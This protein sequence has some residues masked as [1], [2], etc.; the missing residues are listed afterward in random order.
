[1][2]ENLYDSIKYF[3]DVEKAPLKRPLH[4]HIVHSFNRSKAKYEIFKIGKS[5]LKMEP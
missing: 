2:L 1:M 4:E 3:A 5:G